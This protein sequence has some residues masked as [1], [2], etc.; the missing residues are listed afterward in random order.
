[1]F[2]ASFE[3]AVN[4]FCFGVCGRQMAFTNTGHLG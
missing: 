2:Y 3:H 1:V 4:K